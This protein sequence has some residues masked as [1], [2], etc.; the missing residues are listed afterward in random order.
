MLTLILQ[1]HFVE[2]QTGGRFLIT[3]NGRDITADIKGCNIATSILEEKKHP[4]IV[5]S[6]NQGKESLSYSLTYS[7]KSISQLTMYGVLRYSCSERKF[8]I[9]P[10]FMLLPLKSSE[11]I[12]D[13]ISSFWDEKIYKITFKKFII[14]FG[15]LISGYLLVYRP[16]KNIWERS[17]ARR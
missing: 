17:K 12:V 13:R 6:E 1:D 7:L 15:M 8:I 11:D 9:E 3:Q 2:N 10:E 4:N 14:C 16:F 5:F